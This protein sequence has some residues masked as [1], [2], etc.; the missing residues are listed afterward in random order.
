MQNENESSPLSERSGPPLVNGRGPLDGFLRRRC[1]ASSASSDSKVVIDLTDDD[2]S[3]PV[4]CRGSPAPAA[5]RPPAKTKQQRKDRTEA[6]GKHKDVTDTPETQTANFVLITD[7]EAEEEEEE[8]EEDLATSVSQLDTT[9]QDS[10]SEPEEQNEL[11]NKSTQSPSSASSMSESS[12]ENTKTGDS[13]PT[14]TPKVRTSM[15]AVYGIPS[16]LL[17]NCC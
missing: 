8:E 10:D 15:G 17:R 7:E 4:K 3:S 1:P 6:A 9:T 14:T 2:K 12:P 11:E 16:F 5:S 13:T